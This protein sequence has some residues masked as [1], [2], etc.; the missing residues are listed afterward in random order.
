LKTNAQAME[1]R[2][3]VKPDEEKTIHYTVHY[4]W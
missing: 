3:Q 2:V 4:L 1:F